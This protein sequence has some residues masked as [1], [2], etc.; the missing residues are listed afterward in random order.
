M[1]EKPSL[2]A[3]TEKNCAHLNDTKTGKDKKQGKTHRISVS[4]RYL[5]P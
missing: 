2:L 4:P 1:T 3:M 5:I